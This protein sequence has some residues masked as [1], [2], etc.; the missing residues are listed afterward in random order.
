MAVWCDRIVTGGILFL[1]LFTPIAFG[2]VHPWAFSIMEG[3]V[4]LLVIVWMGKE[5]MRRAGSKEQGAEESIRNSKFEIRNFVSP[6]T[7]PLLLFTGLILVQLL[8]LPPFLLRVLSPTTYQLYATSFPGWP[9]R[10]PYGGK[11]R[12]IANSELR[13]ANEKQ[14]TKSREQEARSEEQRAGGREQGAKSE[15]QAVRSGE[16]IANSERST[17]HQPGPSA[18]VLLPTVDEVRNGAAIPFGPPAPRSPLQTFGSSPSTP[19]SALPAPGFQGSEVGDQRSDNSSRDSQSASSLDRLA[20]SHSPFAFFSTWFPLSVAPS[21]TR[22]TLLKFLSYAALFF[23]VLFYPLGDW[24]AAEQ[25]ARNTEPRATIHDQ[26]HQS[27]IRNSHF[28]PPGSLFPSL[29]L[30]RARPF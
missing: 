30:S 2:S 4:F 5:A 17:S 28:F 1:V 27:A 16:R 15:E 29:L 12:E 24:R 11:Q 19:A 25:G 6:L 21:L 26:R 3:L 13:M 20:I 10:G 23:L 22:T 8:P 9:A 7:L 14:E 18:P